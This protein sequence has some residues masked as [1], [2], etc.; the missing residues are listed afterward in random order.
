MNLQEIKKR[1]LDFRDKRDWSQFHDPKNLSA[2]I[3]I[4]A[5]ELQEIF[6]WCKVAESREIA[7]EKKENIAEEVADILM[8][9]LLFAHETGI[10]IEQAILDKI[11]KN[12]KKYPVEKARGVSKKYNDF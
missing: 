5:A 7:V 6:L 8:F 1:I 12:N 9:V 3:A 4:E 2:A 10:D 11:E